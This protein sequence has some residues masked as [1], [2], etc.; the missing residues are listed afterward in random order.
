MS[1]IF[2]IKG[3][4][5]QVGSLEEAQKLVQEGKAFF[6]ANTKVHLVDDTGKVYNTKGRFA[7]KLLSKGYGLASPIDLVAEKYASDNSGV[8]GAIKQGAKSFVNQALL[9]V[10]SVIS[11]AGESE[12]ERKKRE[13]L[14]R[15]QKSA[16][17]IGGTLGFGT[18]LLYGGTVTGAT[19]AGNI[20]GRGAEKVA[21]KLLGTAAERGIA[22]RV[23]A[24]SIVGATKMGTVAGAWEAPKAIAQAALGDPE[25]ASEN[26]L[27]S[28]GV[29]ALLGGVGTPIFKGLSK[30]IKNAIEKVRTEGVIDKGQEVAN[31]Y[32]ITPKQ[33]SK[34]STSVKEDLPTLFDDIGYQNMFKASDAVEAISASKKTAGKVIGE[35]FKTADDAINTIYAKAPYE[36]S[37]LLYF[38]DILDDV[39]KNLAQYKTLNAKGKEVFMSDFATQGKKI[40]AKIA[41][42]RRMKIDS[43]SEL[44][45]QRGLIGANVDFKKF[46]GSE[47]ENLV[48]NVYKDLYFNLNDRIRNQIVPQIAEKIGNPELTEKLLKATRQYHVMTSLEPLVQSEAWKQAGR[49][50]IGFKDMMS[51][52]AGGNLGDIQ[53]ALGGLAYSKGLKY[54]P[55]AKFL[56]ADIVNN[57]SKKLASIPSAVDGLIA[58]S[59]I[60]SVTPAG[61]STLIHKPTDRDK[62]LDELNDKLLV[63]IKDPQKLTAIIADNIAPFADEVDDD[64]RMY[65][66]QKAMQVADYIQSIAPKKPD[67]SILSKEKYRPSDAEIAHFERNVKVALDPYSI[68]DEL[69]NGTVTK[70][71]VATVRHLHPKVFNKIISEVNE[72]IAKKEKLPYYARLKLSYFTG[73]PLD[74][75]INSV[76]QLQQNYQVT[77]QAQQGRPSSLKTNSNQMMSEQD[78]L[79]SRK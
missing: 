24:D 70:D 59:A 28:I 48:N 67:I 36:K 40:E 32:N 5:I 58:K 16:Q 31:I 75:S 34:L 9:G 26:I 4:P 1:Q 44:Q 61:I 55:Q 13:A 3:N 64:T 17:V 76:Q 72:I 51:I 39:E 79:L 73:I 53:G 57:T 77:N 63:N 22:K 11:E 42:L 10:P 69:R 66:T 46:G 52:I 33:Y 56:L 35:T 47:A 6:D 30:P 7:T 27:A 25:T 18:S 62:Y 54:V 74:R 78:R 50:V 60:K 71:Q 20:L 41:E 15:E 38:K 49:K 21:T 8:V 43:L 12:L 19:K 37:K 68:I 45:R 2:D 14:E 29:G 65:M 23:L